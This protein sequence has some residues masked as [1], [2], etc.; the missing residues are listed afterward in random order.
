MPETIGFVGV[1]RMG[2]NMAR[3]LKDKGY[4]V[5]AVYDARPEAAQALSKELGAEL[6]S[7][8]ARVTELAEVVFTVVTDD[9]AMLKVFAPPKT[10]DSLLRN[11]KGK[12]FINCATVSPQVH[13]QVE[14]LAKKSDAEAL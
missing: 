11:A 1:G 12:L 9:K 8:L 13:V 7:T 10:A 4:S 6:C 3:R 2:A 5:V 14:K